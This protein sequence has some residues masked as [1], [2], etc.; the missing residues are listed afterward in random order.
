MTRILAV[1]AFVVFSAPAFLTAQGQQ[2]CGSHERLFTSKPCTLR[3]GA[4]QIDFGMKQLP[5]PL[6][7]VTTTR[8]HRSGFESPFTRGLHVIAP[9]G[10]EKAPID[11]A[12]QKPVLGHHD[13][14]M[15]KSVDDVTAAT[16]GPQ[17][18]VSHGGRV[19]PVTP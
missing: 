17:V 8:G 9:V 2:S 16:V 1:L 15:V 19:I 3:A 12:M 14:A 10:K 6:P 7:V 18:H 13:K 4:M 11:C 5:P